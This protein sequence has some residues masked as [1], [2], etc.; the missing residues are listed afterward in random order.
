MKLV[1]SEC[2][3]TMNSSLVEQW[4]VYMVVDWLFVQI[5]QLDPE[6]LKSRNRSRS[7]DISRT[8][9]EGLE[10]SGLGLKGCGLSLSFEAC[11]LVNIS[12]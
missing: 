4:A 2:L 9:F 6:M 5:L 12:D 7:R 8:I 1:Y 10:A 11:D 3:V